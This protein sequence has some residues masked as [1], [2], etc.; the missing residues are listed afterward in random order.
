MIVPFA[1]CHG[2]GR[3][4]DFKM[5]IDLNWLP[6]CDLYWYLQH[7]RL[8]E[9]EVIDVMMRA[10]RPG[11][12]AVDGGACGGFFT[13][14]MAQLVGNTGQVFSY[15][16]ASDTYSRLFKNVAI[17]DLSVRWSSRPLWCCEECVS[18]QKSDHP[19][20]NS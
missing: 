6:D 3:T 4:V 13:I 9:A 11:D 20:Q 14:L 15:E 1:L 10:L 18:L 12:V 16:M 17:N 5:D 2:N 8:P 19:G 7:Q